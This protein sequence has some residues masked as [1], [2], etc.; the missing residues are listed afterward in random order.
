MVNTITDPFLFPGIYE[1]RIL[2]TITQKIEHSTGITILMNYTDIGIS[3]KCKM[4]NENIEWLWVLVPNIE[5]TYTRFIKIIL[6][7]CHII[8]LILFIIH[9][10]YRQ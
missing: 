4:A 3:K 6:Y 9:F 1:V 8:S 5:N 7:T 10:F 2:F